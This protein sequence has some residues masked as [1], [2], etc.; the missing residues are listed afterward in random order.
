MV[1][2]VFWLLLWGM[3]GSL[4]AIDIDGN[5]S[6][7]REGQRLNPRFGEDRVEVHIYGHYDQAADL[8]YFALRTLDDG[9][10]VIGPRT[11]IWLNIDQD[12][13]TGYLIWGWAGGVEWNFDFDTD[14]VPFL[15][16]S[17][18]IQE[19][20][21]EA[22][23]HAYSPSK[24]EVEWAVPGAL[25]PRVEHALGIDI[26]VD[27][28][29]THY[30]PEVYSNPPYT[31]FNV[32]L[33]PRTDFT[34]KIGIVFSETSAEQFY[35]NKAYAQ[36]YLSVQHQAMMAGIPFVLLSQSDLLDLNNIVN[37]DAL[38]F[39][40][41]QWVNLDQLKPL[42]R[43]LKL[44][45]SHYGMGTIV[46][47]DWLTNDEEGG[48]LPGNP[49]ERM[50]EFLGVRRSVGGLV[51]ALS[52]ISTN[53]QHPMTRGYELF[54]DVLMYQSTFYSGFEPF[55]EVG[56]VEVLAEQ[57][58]GHGD[59]EEVYNALI[60]TEN[61]GRH[62]HFA[63]PKFMVDANWLWQGMQW[64][65]YGEKTPVGLKLGRQSSL[66][67]ARNDMDKSM[68]FCQFLD[69]EVP[70]LD[71]FLVKWKRDFNFVGSYYI[72]VGNDTIEACDCLENMGCHR[73]DWALSAPLYQQYIDLGNEIGTHSYTHPFN[74]NLLSPQEL[75]FEFK[76]S[77]DVIRREMNL[78]LCNAAQPGNPENLRVARAMEEWF[79][80]FSG[81]YSGLNQGYPSA[82]GFLAP[83]S[84]MV[85]FAPN[86][87]FDFTM[88][89]F[90]GWDAEFS[91]DYW[92]FQFDQLMN[93]ASTPLMHWPW[94]DYGPT[95]GT[96]D[97]F[98][99]SEAMFENL[100]EFA[101][102]KDTEF[103]TLEDAHF[104]ILNFR[105]ASL[106]V[107][108]EEGVVDVEVT[109][110]GLGQFSLQVYGDEPIRKVENWYAYDGDKIF[111]PQDGGRFRVHLGGEVHDVPTR[112]SALPMRAK[113]QKLHGDGRR[114]AF[115][116]EGEGMVEIRLAEGL[117]GLASIQGGD[118]FYVDQNKV[119][120][121]FGTHGV[122]SVRILPPPEIHSI[123]RLND[124]PD[125]GFKLSLSHADHGKHYGLQYTED[126]NSGDWRD[127]DVALSRAHHGRMEWS[128]CGLLNG[129]ELANR[130]VFFRVVI[131][132]NTSFS[133]PD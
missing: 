34:R 33:P 120:M 108:H 86:M 131:L 28:N 23:H 121:W 74:I 69:V 75:E 66:F 79:T 37:L 52:V 9:P 133:T 13:E 91:L 126:L 24:R 58:I 60:A 10:E 45:L 84:P 132:E 40:G 61:R 114:L 53:N 44:A 4:L 102:D 35:D 18:E 100:I 117:P 27:I 11:T 30:Y 125:L 67:L 110:T 22:L 85:Y 96:W 105:E 31:L 115:T 56:V 72:N 20:V 70:L 124:C 6:D 83:D 89:E 15:Y 64:V 17:G 99:Y 77:R 54:E 36:L 93:H 87:F 109:G 73:T 65:V 90:L 2:K 21:S 101:Y 14:G 46:A 57:I 51:P 81:G 59:E 78:A 127:A 129:N 119:F 7:W 106:D 26:L 82:M 8:Y 41:F 62:L 94:H 25:I 47:G 95:V 116:F 43:N 63:T 16:R 111:L 49:Y 39:P 68:Y 130:N 128:L 98:G 12:S 107:S 104:R 92:K 123:E 76:E 1:Y 112:I 38:V 88:I 19:R 48:A 29:D 122:H 113:L 42:E 103:T 5:L 118:E 3:S 97:G 55:G 71:E 32:D 80:Y 50:M